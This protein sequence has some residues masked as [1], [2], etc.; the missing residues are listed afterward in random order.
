MRIKIMLFSVLLLSAALS[1]CTPYKME[2]RQGNYVTPEM[3][4]KL[5]VGMTKQQVRYVLGTPV[6]SDVFRGNRWDYVYSLEQER[7]VV[8]RQSM[9]LYF[10][11]DVLTR[12][13]DNKPPVE[14]VPVQTDGQTKDGEHGQD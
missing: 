4:E 11:G 3:R 10:D 8:E 2:I 9:T 7:K 13:V 6:V 14:T 5:K 1:A 12:I